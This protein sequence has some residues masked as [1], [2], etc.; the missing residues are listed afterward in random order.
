[1]ATA[2]DLLAFETLLDRAVVMSSRTRSGLYDC[3]YAA[4]AEREACE[5]LT[6]DQKLVANLKPH[7]PFIK[8]LTSLP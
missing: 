6:D 4:L 3:L 8:S 7:Y 2:P 5:L 1:M